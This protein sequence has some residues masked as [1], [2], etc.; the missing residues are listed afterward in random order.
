MEIMP[1]MMYIHLSISL[2]VLLDL[3]LCL[4][5]PHI[6]RQLACYFVGL[7]VSNNEGFLHLLIQK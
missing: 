1:A 3:I 6:D 2:R 4:S 5:Q 7:I